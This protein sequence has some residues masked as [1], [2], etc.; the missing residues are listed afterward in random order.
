MKYESFLK[1]EMLSA[2]GCTEPIAIAFGAARVAA[3]LEEEIKHMEAI[4][5]ANIIKNVKSVIIPNSGGQK[6]IEV[7]CALGACTKAY[8]AELEVLE[9]VNEEMLKQAEDLKHKIDVKLKAGVANLYIQII[10][11][12][13]SGKVAEVII[14]YDHTNITYLRLDDKIL[15]NNRENNK[16]QNEEECKLEFDEI[17]EWCKNGDISEI[18]PLLKNQIKLNLAIAEE[19]LKNNYG[20]NIGKIVLSQNT[21]QSRIIAHAAAGSD[22]R[23]S[24]CSMPVVINSGSGNQGITVCV[25]VA[26]HA[27]DINATEDELYRA[28]AFANLCAFYLK[29]GVGKLSAYCGVVSAGSSAICGIAMLDKQ[30]KEIIERTLINSLAVTSGMICDGAKPS[31]AAKIAT[32]LNTAFMGYEQAKRN[33]SFNYDDGIIKNNLENTI[34]AIST[35]AKEGM[36]QTDIVILEE[37]IKKDS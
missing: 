31:C 23:M 34:K 35:V 22:A 6:S 9:C 3:L 30:P 10:A 1:K 13:I 18:I 19:G 26:L 2:F 37:M 14:E 11:T 7:A 15:I 25:P 5:S 27:K 12:G 17:Y 20:S 24:G 16:T 8:E 33:D 29:S 21:K 4:C 36:K 28:L 32:A